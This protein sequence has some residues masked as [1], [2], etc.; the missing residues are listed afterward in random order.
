M[1]CAL[2]PIHRDLSFL[3]TPNHNFH[4]LVASRMRELAARVINNELSALQDLYNTVP[5][6][7]TISFT[8]QLEEHIIIKNSDKLGFVYSYNTTQDLVEIRHDALGFHFSRNEWQD[9]FRKKTYTR[10]YIS[11]SELLRTV[12]TPAPTPPL[13]PVAASSAAVVASPVSAPVNTRRASPQTIQAPPSMI[14]RGVSYVLAMFQK[15]W[16]TYRFF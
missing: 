9:L 8:T 10:T 11:N 6:N 12:P 16:N 7:T 5:R 15:V 3:M 14:V 13:V 4:S 2:G 1:S